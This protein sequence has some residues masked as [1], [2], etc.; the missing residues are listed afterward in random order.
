MENL[1]KRFDTIT[2]GIPI[3]NYLQYTSPVT[4][5]SLRY[6][7]IRYT[8]NVSFKQRRYIKPKFHRELFWIAA[9]RKQNGANA[10]KNH[11]ET[12]EVLR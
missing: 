9:N 12:I 1:P 11:L 8:N 3:V 4:S 6:Q 2:I 7:V 10:I 5:E